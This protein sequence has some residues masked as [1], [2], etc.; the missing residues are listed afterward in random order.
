[1]LVARGYK[2]KLIAA[3]IA[4][5]VA[6]PRAEAIQFDPRLASIPKI[7]HKHHR[8]M[9]GSDP[10]LAEVYKKPPITAFK[11]PPNLRNKLIRSKVPPPPTSARG[12]TAAGSQHSAAHPR[13]GRDIPSTTNLRPKQ[14]GMRKCRKPLC[15]TCDFV[16]EGKTVKLTATGKKVEINDAVSCDTKSYI[17]CITCRK[18]RCRLQYIGKSVVNFRTRMSQ[19]RNYVANRMLQKATGEHFNR[20][21]H[22]ISDMIMTIIEKVH[23]DDPMVLSVREEHWIKKGNTKYKGINRNKG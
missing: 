13:P 7:V 14:K 12:R 16:Q 2:R 17:Y 23:S 6:V 1:M 8:T 9:V 11:R 3:A 10:H 4:R 19:H 20:P 22:K 15:E 18:D 5:A 21:G